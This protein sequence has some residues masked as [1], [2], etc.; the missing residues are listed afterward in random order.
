MLQFTLDEELA[1]NRLLSLQQY[2]DQIC[3]NPALR[4]SP[5]LVAFLTKP[6]EGLLHMLKPERAIPMGDKFMTEKS[7]PMKVFD[8]EYPGG[9][10]NM[11]MDYKLRSVTHEISL[12]VDKLTPLENEA[13]TICKEIHLLQDR[14]SKLYNNLGHICLSISEN[15]KHLA[16]TV[17]FPN[18]CKMSEM[19]KGLQT[20]MKE[21]TRMA[22]MESQNF[23]DNIRAMFEFSLREMEGIKVVDFF[24][25]DCKRNR[26][27]L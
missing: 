9:K 20:F 21:Q 18:V 6:E 2:L 15:Y 12:N 5:E 4:Y 8:L 3:E 24:D 14:L 27:F 19:Y 13:V 11:M 22:T 26:A 25:V 7:E 23:S 10:I 17:K 16:A 1:H